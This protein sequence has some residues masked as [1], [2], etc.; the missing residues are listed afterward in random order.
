[1]RQLDPLST[2]FLSLETQDT[3]GHF[4]ALSILDPRGREGFGFDSLRGFLAE[5]IRACPEFG[6]KI[7]EVPLGL[8]RPSWVEATDYT[9]EDHI[10][11][12]A[13]P[14]PGGARELADFAGYLYSRPL[15]RRR[16]LW[17]IF[18]LE[19][20][21]GNR[22]ALLWKIHH[23]LMDGM[24]GAGLMP[25][26]FDME[27]DPAPRRR[28]VLTPEHRAGAPDPWWIQVPR[29]IR[30]TIER[31]VT[32]GRHLGALAKRA[33]TSL[34]DGEPRAA[35]PRVSFNGSVGGR[36]S[37]AWSSVSLAEVKAIKEQLG[38]TVN[39]VVLALTSASMRRYLENHDELPDE[40]LWAAMPVSVREEGDDRISN[41]VR[42]VNVRLA[43]NVEDAI[44]RV[45]AIHA[46]TREAKRRGQ[47][48]EVDLLAVLGESLAPAAISLVTRGCAAFPEQVPLPANVCVSN[49]P[50]SAMPFY[51]G[52]ARVERLI[53]ISLLTPTQGLNVTVVS[54]CG[55]IHFG[56][57]SDADLVQAPWA[58]AEGVPKA[59]LDLQEALAREADAE[60]DLELLRARQERKKGPMRLA[61]TGRAGGRITG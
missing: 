25:L 44:E 13:V 23:C 5:R 11:R 29:G 37:L 19:G 53:P 16:P 33:F 21:P 28:V 15:D 1:M 3:P 26:L 45:L 59:L 46:S 9:P 43:T 42:N 17:E 22:V 41:Q 38:V 14:A 54:Y 18:V 56:F 2:L 30:N 47:T 31:R 35:V 48:D 49:V 12:M 55:E 34:F 52:G 7:A 51:V 61:R 20:L 6:W 57:T 36:R 39:D 8:D 60:P 40:S 58:L 50:F 10:T 32:M 4:G 27:A 24:S